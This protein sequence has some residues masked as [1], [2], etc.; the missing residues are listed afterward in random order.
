[1][2][3]PFSS[4]QTSRSTRWRSNAAFASAIMFSLTRAAFASTAVHAVAGKS[5]MT[6][7]RKRLT[8][9]TISDNLKTM[10]Y[11][12]RGKIAIE[13]DR[14]T[15]ELSK[16]EKGAFPFDHIVFTNIGNPHAVAQKAITWPRQ[17]MALLQLPNAI[18]I[19]HPNASQMF[20]A[21][22]LERAREMK[23]SLGGSGVGA[24][25]HS[26]GVR[27]F[28]NDV[29]RFIEQ[30]DGAEP[31]SVDIEKIFLTSGASEAIG[32][33]MTALIKDSSCGIMIP[34]P[35]YPL[36]SA[37]LDLLGGH[38]VGYYMDEESGWGL[39]MEELERS[40]A[41][42]KAKGINV[43]GLVLINPGNPTGQVSSPDEVKEV[44]KFCARHNL[45]LLSDEVYQENIYREGDEFFSARR[46]ADELGMIKDDAIQLCSF[47]S[48]SKGVTGE[49]GQRGGY[50]EM[51]GIDDDV[52]DI[53]YKLAASKLCSNASG[54]AMV[55]L[56]CRGPN[57]GDVSYESHEQEKKALFE[58]LR[59][60]ALLVSK[61]LDSIPGFSCQPAT[62]AMYCFPSVD[63]PPGVIKASQ[64]LG[65]SPDTLYSLDLLQSTGICVVPASGFGQK[66][67]RFGFRT[68][69]L[70][71]ESKSVVERI[72]DHYET[73]CAKY[74]D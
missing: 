46:A 17:V 49:C 29:A 27:Q 10:E 13:A 56:M 28:R 34:I 11:A 5:S 67:G 68:T 55:S 53:L 65:F 16:Q 74:S 40:L 30:R 26:K 38:K 43:A 57:P 1:M 52:N 35:Q 50:V 42:A 72:R 33:L 37:T 48:V 71:L 54:Q 58:G 45:V 66:E 32:M 59:D 62:G 69:F 3:A 12:V 61:G 7:R 21:D 36:Y 25:T 6:P 64:E 70:S 15:Q 63:L 60:R 73:F 22:A 8:I 47:H 2:T 44:V 24:Y 39:N 23:A 31:G 4:N 51:V 19:D 41:D 14:I 18:G 9:D 20:P